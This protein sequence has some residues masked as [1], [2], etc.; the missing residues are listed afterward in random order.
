MIFSER[1]WDKS[2][3]LKGQNL[4]PVRIVIVVDNTQDAVKSINWNCA[5]VMGGCDSRG[6]D[7]K[8]LSEA[9]GTALQSII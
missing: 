3:K 4:V 9:R 5:I 7:E 8:G 2:I 1:N 6:G